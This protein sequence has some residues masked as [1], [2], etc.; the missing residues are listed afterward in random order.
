MRSQSL[1]R[2]WQVANVTLGLFAAAT[3][4]L[5][6]AYAPRIVVPGAEGFLG[7]LAAPAA[8]NGAAAHRITGFEPESPLLSAGVSAG[9]L[10]VDPPR[11]RFLVGEAVKL[12][13]VHERTVR[14]V[15]VRAARI[16]RLA[17][18]VENALDFGLGILSF[19]LGLTIAVRRRGDLGALVLALDFFLA[20]GGL[21][22]APLPSGR[23]AAS[24]LVWGWLGLLLA[25]PLLAYFSLVFEDGY[26][27]RA[28][29][30]ILRAVVGIGAAAGVWTVM[31]AP[32]IFGRAW[33]SPEFLVTRARPAL[34]FAGVVLCIVAFT[35]TW[36]HVEAERRE[37]LR[38]LFFGFAVTLV[39][40]CIFAA[41]PIG[42]FGYA[43]TTVLVIGVVTDSVVAI[44]LL[45]LTYAILRHRVIDLGF[46]INRALVFAAFTV[47][48]LVSFG[49]VEWLVDHFVRFENRKS[50]VLLDGIIA[51]ALFLAFH[52]VRHWIETLVERVFFRS[53]H[54]K[55]AALDRFL[56][57]APQFSQPDAL[58]E[59]LIAA[60][61]AY[62][63]SR[64]SGIYQRDET[65]RFILGRST[66]D[67]L[68][69]ELGADA[70]VV[71]E[72]KTFCAPVQMGGRLALGSAAL[73]LPM[74]RRAELVGLLAVGRKIEREIYRPDEIDN[75]ARTARQVGLDLYAL[76]LEQLEQRKLELEQQ[77][78]GLRQGLRS[79]LQPLP[80]NPPLSGAPVTDSS[81]S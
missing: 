57:T 78:E 77:N 44:T 43:T 1:L 19:V 69:R 62:A 67:E 6:L 36:R 18:P 51:L 15:E 5:G 48:L 60:V 65:G 76:R 58:T 79:L 33:F 80:A 63:G 24:L 46:V 47:L 21:S 55:E 41:F 40:F 72:M 59:A 29:P 53:W 12:Q 38:W 22:P 31:T 11:G 50:S 54:L 49:I 39:N 35:D 23:L 37:R 45:I 74:V 8:F 61:D 14:T 3:L 16:D 64:G 81:G 70:A 42:V 32:Y 34:L 52:R 9:D 73:A 28:R 68:P 20:V 56:E 4:A 66:L 17:T 30:W 7:Y 71:V 2:L 13:I 10:I 25:L 26:Q 75:L 27:S